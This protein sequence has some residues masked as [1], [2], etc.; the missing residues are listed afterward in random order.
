MT[1]SRGNLTILTDIMN[2]LRAKR[3]KLTDLKS[4]CAHH[5]RQPKQNALQGTTHRTPLRAYHHARPETTRDD[6][7]APGQPR[8]RHTT[9]F[10]ERAG[11]QEDRPSYVKLDTFLHGAGCRKTLS[12]VGIACLLPQLGAHAWLSAASA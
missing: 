1:A 2:V 3:T 6:S 10:S 5:V 8:G 11:T 12:P 4:T 9:L 7:P